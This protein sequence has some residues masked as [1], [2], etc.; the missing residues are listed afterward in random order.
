MA[1]ALRK[2]GG[3][4]ELCVSVFAVEGGKEAFGKGFSY[5]KSFLFYLA[6]L[7]LGVVFINSVCFLDNLTPFCFVVGLVGVMRHSSR[8]VLRNVST[9]P[10]HCLKRYAWNK[11]LPAFLYTGLEQDFPVGVNR[12]TGGG[13]AMVFTIA[14]RNHSN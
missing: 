14:G 7:F 5:I 11:M 10:H 4:S 1:L 3:F 8:D 12:K 6:L 13:K 9:A 2:G